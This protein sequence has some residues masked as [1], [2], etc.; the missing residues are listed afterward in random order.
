VIKEALRLHA[1]TCFPFER[2]V[3]AEG[4]EVCGFYIPPGTV[5]GTMAPLMNLNKDVFGEDAES[6]RP[7]RWLGQDP[8]RL[9]LMDRTFFTVSEL[10]PFVGGRPSFRPSH[11]V[12]SPEFF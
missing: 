11:F 5:I 3:P 12:G 6:F 1:P 8:D 4:T 7:E 10:S 9:K 2:I